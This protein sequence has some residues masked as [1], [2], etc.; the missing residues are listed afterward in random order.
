MSPG[1][2][3]VGTIGYWVSA[4][5]YLALAGMLIFSWRGRFDR[6]LLSLALLV[7][8]IWSAVAGYSGAP[9]GRLPVVV[10]EVE[11]F[12]DV[13]WLIFLLQA[14]NARYQAVVRAATMLRWGAIASGCVAFLLLVGLLLMDLTGASGT[15][16]LASAPVYLGRVLLS[17]FALVLIEQLFRGARPER[18]RAVKF[19]YIAIGGMFLYDFFLYADALVFGILDDS[20]WLARGMFTVLLVPLIG[21]S[22]VTGTP[23]WS[24]DVYVSHN[25]VFYTVAL[26]FAGFYLVML[27]LGAELIRIY[28]GS[29]ASIVRFL[30]LAGGVLSLAVLMSSAR[31]RAHMRVFVGKHFFN[32]KYDYRD[33]WL[34]IIRTLSKGGAGAHLLERSIQAIAQIV[35]SRGGVLWLQRDH[36]FYEPAAQWEAPPVTGVRERADGSLVRFLEQWQWVISR[37]EYQDEPDIYQDLVLP[38]WLRAYPGAW[39]VVPLMLDVELLGFIV[40]L[41]PSVRRDINWE[42]RDLLKTAAR[43]AATH[44]A[45]LMAAQAL[46][47]AREFQAFSKLSAFVMHD[48]KNLIAQLSLVVSNA[49]RHRHNPAFLEDAI[50]TVDNS[51]TK[52]N[53]LMA[54]LKAGGTPAAPASENV[55]LVG[56][57]R[58]VVAGR[59]ARQPAPVFVSDEG[60]LRIRANRDRAA[61]VLEHVIENAQDAT[62]ADG[63]VEVRLKFEQDH[64]VIDVKDSGCGMDAEF[65]SNQLFRP[66]RSTKGAGMGIGVFE[67]REFVRELGGDIEVA[68]Q[69]GRG[70]TFRIRV[71]AARGT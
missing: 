56:L 29:W 66:F 52:M 59:S 22:T 65:M 27:L 62:P 16:R 36:G 49:A 57:V 26:G 67:S 45:Q 46:I 39:L 19:L 25:V 32:Y 64:A 69:P 1:M 50:K 31:L 68:S 5:A 51:V 47:E 10:L 7:T 60:A 48:L 15:A 37:E 30:V 63:M 2:A 24:R 13:V 71:P 58:E 70:T 35:D 3:S 40:L 41:K 42:D 61:A 18:R 38:E 28:A 12:R 53:R 11:I 8:A 33:E 14:L 54:Q 4:A 6:V 17:V 34:R 21:L 43:Q 9:A 20:L 44:V 23:R 55:D